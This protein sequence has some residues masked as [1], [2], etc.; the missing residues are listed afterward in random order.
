MPD[1]VRENRVDISSTLAIQAWNM[2]GARIDWQGLPIVCELLG[3]DDIENLLSQ[4]TVIR[5]HE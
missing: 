1:E 5:D 2:L 4:L 3:I